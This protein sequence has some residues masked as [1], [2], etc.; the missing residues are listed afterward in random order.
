MFANFVHGHASF[1]GRVPAQFQSR[2]NLFAEN[3]F[4]S[5]RQRFAQFQTEA[6]IVGLLVGQS[7][8]AIPLFAGDLPPKP[9]RWLEFSAHY[10]VREL[11]FRHHQTGMSAAI[12]IS[13]DQKVSPGN[14]VA[15][16]AQSSARGRWP[17][18]GELFWAEL[19]LTL[20]PMCAAAHLESQRRGLPFF[21]K[22]HMSAP[23]F[24]RQITLCDEVTPRALDLVRQPPD[25]ILPFDLA[26]VWHSGSHSCGVRMLTAVHPALE[27]F[28]W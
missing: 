23:G 2:L 8:V 13:L 5:V 25:Q 17:E 10:T 14:F 11:H 4:Q 27:D 22:T 15:H 18:R 3:P 20:F 12:N 9:G 21:A 26:A 6:H 7:H 28:A 16:L 19:D 1:L 24:C